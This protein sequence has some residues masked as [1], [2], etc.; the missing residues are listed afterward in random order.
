M[1]RVL[2]VLTTLTLAALAHAERDLTT[3][4]QDELKL[5]LTVDSGL[6][7]VERCVWPSAS[8]ARLPRILG[9]RVEGRKGGGGTRRC[10]GAGQGSAA[11]ATK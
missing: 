6:D 9:E 2:A 4:V 10:A 11:Q 7:K 5:W 3:M 1:P 8:W